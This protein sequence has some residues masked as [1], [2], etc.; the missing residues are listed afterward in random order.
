MILV[1]GVMLCS[2]SAQAKKEKLQPV[3]PE[4]WGEIEA[5]IQNGWMDFVETSPKLPK[6]YSFALNPGT[7]YYY[8]LYFINYALIKQGYTEQ[9]KNNLDCFIHIA[10]SLGFIPNA[11]GWGESRSQL[12][13]FSMMIRE[14]YEKSGDRDKEWLKG[15]YHA[16]LNEYAFWTNMD[17]N[18]IEDHST[19]IEGLQRW[20]QHADTAEIIEFYDRTLYFRFKHSKDVPLEQKYYVASHRLAEC[21]SMDFTPRYYGRCMDFIPT[22]LNANLY[23]YE[24]NFAFFE[25]ELGIQSSYNWEERAQKRADLINK[26]LWNEERGLYMDYDYVNQEFTSIPCIMAFNVLG[27][28]I[29]PADRMKRFKNNLLEALEVKS[30][31]T[32]CGE[33]EFEDVPYQFGRTAIWGSMQ[34]IAMDALRKSGFEKDAERVALKYVNMVTKNYVDPFPAEYIPFK[35]TEMVKRP[36]GLLWEKFTHDGDINDNEYYC[37]P[38][39]GFTAAPYVLALDI[40]GV[41]GKQQ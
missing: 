39:M 28:Q 35:Q 41:F 32:V 34:F 1:A 25:K 3:Y 24:K 7:L 11:F 10:D 8:D 37:S 9:A 23:Q 13:F 16:A 2:L 29:V 40:L 27:W 12:P 5:Y 31:L 22:D 6:P 19:P 4:K 33:S 18:N 21:E 15:A 20:G 14:Y 26:H 36:Y 17:G 38:I 30:G